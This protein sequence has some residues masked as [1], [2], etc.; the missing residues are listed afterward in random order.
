MLNFLFFPMKYKE[1]MI[2][3]GVG[4]GQE[5][6]ATTEISIFRTT[7]FI[8]TDGFKW[9]NRVVMVPKPPLYFTSILCIKK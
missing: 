6:T 3:K 1:I 9:G 4:A 8:C 5:A 2:T 7:K